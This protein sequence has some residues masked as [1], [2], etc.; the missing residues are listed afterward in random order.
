MYHIPC[1]GLGYEQPLLSPS[2]PNRWPW[3]ETLVG[4]R[5]LLCVGSLLVV[6]VRMCRMAKAVRAFPG[7]QTA[8]RAE[9]EVCSLLPD[10]GYSLQENATEAEELPVGPMLC[11]MPTAGKEIS[12]QWE[13]GSQHHSQVFTVVHSPADFSLSIHQL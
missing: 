6:L 9:Q 2:L 4:S 1:Q 5:A 10:M 8:G 7:C 13:Q 12:S 3:E 11:S